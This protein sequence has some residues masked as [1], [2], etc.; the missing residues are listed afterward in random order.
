[1]IIKERRVDEVGWE[2]AKYE[3]LCRGETTPKFDRRLKC[4]YVREGSPYLRIAPVKMEIAHRNPNIYIYH[5]IISD[6]EIAVIKLIAKP[7][8]SLVMLQLCYQFFSHV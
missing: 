5:G 2:K 8:V 6:R 7:R 3:A 1:M 4:R